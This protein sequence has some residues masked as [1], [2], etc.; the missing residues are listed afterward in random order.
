MKLDQATLDQLAALE[1]GAHN[2]LETDDAEIGRSL[3]DLYRMEL[4]DPVGSQVLQGMV[5]LK[6]DL[7]WQSLARGGPRFL[8]GCRRMVRTMGTADPFLRVLIDIIHR[9]PIAM[10]DAAVFTG[11]FLAAT[12]STIETKNVLPLLLVSDEPYEEAQKMLRSA[13]RDHHR[14]P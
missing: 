6:V 9:R 4:P 5:R 3:D 8:E 2:L 13:L 7:H 11:A 10:D 1:I 14:T 12:G